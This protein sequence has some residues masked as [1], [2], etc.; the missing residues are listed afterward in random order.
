MSDTQ[1]EPVT[2][3]DDDDTAADGAAADGDSPE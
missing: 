3:D 1:P 2:P